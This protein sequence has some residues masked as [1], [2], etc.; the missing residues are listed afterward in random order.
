MSQNLKTISLLEEQIE[1]TL[2]NLWKCRNCKFEK[3]LFNGKP[4]FDKTI[5]EKY[6]YEK[7]TKLAN[8]YTV[9][10][11]RSLYDNKY[12]I[13]FV[14]ESDHYDKQNLLAVQLFYHIIENYV[15][16][17]EEYPRVNVC[18][19]F[20]ITEAMKSHLPA[21]IFKNANIFTRIFSLCTLYPVIGSKNKLFGLGYD[22]K[23]IRYNEYKERKTYNKKDFDFIL[24]GDPIALIFNSLPGDLI[25]CSRII[26][27]STAF[28]DTQI[29]KVVDLKRI[30]S[31]VNESG[32]DP[33]IMSE[34]EKKREIQPL[35]N[36]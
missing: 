14:V 10:L 13:Y 15:Y 8:N 5:Y 33:V 34:I 27:D 7:Y 25:V 29:R 24:S 35:T 18:L 30:H 20:V 12:E 36:I 28:K 31:C 17:S 1:T 11:C 2:K 23:I 9:Y 22:Y 21:Q 16:E 6:K 32:I 3:K 26:F 19:S 4:Y